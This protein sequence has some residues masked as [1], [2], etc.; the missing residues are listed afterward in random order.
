MVTVL[1]APLGLFSDG[2]YSVTGER[3]CSLLLLWDF[4]IDTAVL[5]KGSVLA[6]PPR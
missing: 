6:S 2:C 3:K 1:T 5:F 4:L